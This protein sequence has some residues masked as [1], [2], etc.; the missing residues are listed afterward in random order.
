MS[1]ALFVT[2]ARSVPAWV[3]SY[4]RRRLNQHAFTTELRL[5]FQGGASG[6]DRIANQWAQTQGGS[7]ASVT[8]PAQWSKHGRAAGPR[9]NREMVNVACAL[10]NC[11]WEIVVV[12]FPCGASKGTRDMIKQAQEAGLTVE[13]HELLETTK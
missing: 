11:G 8:M 7:L 1:L 2:G 13:V 5:V 9:R 6:V 10:R 12:A 3:G 4:I